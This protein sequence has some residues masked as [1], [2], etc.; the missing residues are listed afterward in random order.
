MKKLAFDG[1]TLALNK[2]EDHWEFFFFI[3]HRT[4]GKG[5]TR[6]HTIIY[7]ITLKSDQTA[8]S[9]GEMVKESVTVNVENR[10][11]SKCNCVALMCKTNIH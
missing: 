6:C 7:F 2:F 8:L 3:G 11:L 10:S 9:D 1:L 4:A 5:Q